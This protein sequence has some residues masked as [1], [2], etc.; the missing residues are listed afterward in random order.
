MRIL[1]TN[2]DGIDSPG[3]RV[4]AKRMRELGEVVVSA[5]EGNR[6][7]CAHSLTLDS[8]LRITEV[9]PGWYACDGTPADCVHLALNGFLREDRPALVVSGINAGGNLGQDITYSGTVMA[10]LEATLLGVPA[11]AVSVEARQDIDFSGAAEMALRVAKRVLADGLP[12]SMLL[13][14]NVPHLPPDR[15]KGL[16]F[17]RQGRRLYGD[18]IHRRVDPRGREYYWIGGQDLGFEEIEGSDVVA[19][20]QGYASLTPISCDLTDFAM[21]EEMSKHLW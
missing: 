8:P 2:D 17:T 19:V 13:N 3:I 14:L 12:K 6:S 7:A 4:L 15:I 18:E 5:P 21:L 10:A 20:R 9:Q 16:K 1:L 11:F